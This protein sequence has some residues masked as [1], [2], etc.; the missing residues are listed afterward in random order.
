MKNWLALMVLALCSFTIGCEDE[1]AEPSPEQ[2][3]QIHAGH[4][5][6]ME[7]VQQQHEQ[8]GQTR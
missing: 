3:Q 2:Q 5:Q 6:Y 7:Q 1:P 4:E 8:K